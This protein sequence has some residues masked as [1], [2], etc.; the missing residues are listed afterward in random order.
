M[1]PDRSPAFSICWAAFLTS[2]SGSSTPFPKRLPRCLSVGRISRLS[3]L[4]SELSEPHRLPRIAQPLACRPFH[5]VHDVAA[6][7][8][9]VQLT[10]ERRVPTNV[11]WRGT[12]QLHVVHELDQ[13]QNHAASAFL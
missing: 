11:A 8:E 1:R 5:R 12:R 4:V 3:G 13:L 6:L 9:L 2:P 7:G 10:N